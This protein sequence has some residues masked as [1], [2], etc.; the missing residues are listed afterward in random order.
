[1]KKEEFTRLARRFPSRKILV[2]GDAMLD[3]FQYGEVCR[4]S[5]EAPVPVIEI[6]EEAFHLGGSA[7]VARNIR[8]LGAEPLLVGMVGTDTESG[9]ILEELHH[10][11]MDASGLLRSPSRRTTRKTRI[12]AG[13]QQVCRADREDRRPFSSQ[14][15]REILSLVAERIDRVDA[16]VV[17]DYA[18]GLVT[19]PV[20]RKIAAAC[21][22]RGT[23]LVADPKAKDFSVYRGAT[24]ITPNLG[25]AAIAARVEIH[26]EASLVR[27]GI[28]LLKIARAHAIL[29]TRGKEGV[30]LMESGRRPWH[31]PTVAR[32]VFDVTGAGDTLVAAL[33]I[34]AASG[35]TLAKAALIANHAAGIAVAKLG[36]ATA[37]VE[38]ILESL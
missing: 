29:I 11:G 28:R 27:A 9:R 14:E 30:S 34:A 16:V 5:P 13:S 22:R 19:P 1:M 26:D 35:A 8:A 10:L 4:I 38:E 7:N 21:R 31:L 23:L 3:E 20:F 18:K 36:T 25:E 32:E 12:I 2:V 24:V 15:E 6:R 17:S 37:S 33:T